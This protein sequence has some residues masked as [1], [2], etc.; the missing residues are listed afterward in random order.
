MI[1]HI[2]SERSVLGAM[3]KS[4]AAVG[5]ATD[6]LRPDDFA[7][8]AN[9]EIF[10]AMLSLAF[11]SKTIDLVTLDAELTRR[12]KLDMV[13]GSAYLVELIRA[14]P[15]AVN[16]ESYI[17]IVA[18]KSKLRNVMKIAEAINRRASAD[19]ANPDK[20]IELIEGAC[21]DITNQTRFS[22]KRRV[23]GIDAAMMAFEAAEKEE[24]HIPTGFA[25]LD[26]MMAG[27]FVKPE[28]TI[29]GARPGRGKSS[30]LLAA[31]MNAVR[32]GFKVGY[33]SL[34]MSATQIGQRM[35]SAASLVSLNKIRRGG[36]YLTEQEWASLTAGLERLGED[37]MNDRLSIYEF[38]SMSVERLALIVRHAVRR[39]E[40]DVLAVDYIQLLRTVEKTNSDF[41]RLGVVSKALKQLTLECNIPIIT[42]AQV[43]RQADK[44]G[45]DLR[46]PTLDEL[47]GSGDLEQDADNVLLIHSP[48][49]PD[50]PTIKKMDAEDKHYGIWERSRNA[51]AAPFMVDVAKQRQGPNG[52]TW[53]LF[54]PMNM[55]FF[56]DMTR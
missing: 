14:V 10:D 17:S 12:G 21:H 45:K 27:G 23:T 48:E 54:K 35:L 31:S 52:R 37:G 46:P 15:S 8:P 7:D 24:P 39:K 29:I 3:L 33:F 38:Y 2:E 1:A 50:D 26:D 51:M 41:E 9:R 36:K 22:D 6:R 47:R 20:L 53:C 19:D 18:E 44:Q 11:K 55:R 16:V 43:K 28:L 56:E 32:N 40:L 34:E 49:G 4:S 5:T 42:A 25:E 13:G 30:F